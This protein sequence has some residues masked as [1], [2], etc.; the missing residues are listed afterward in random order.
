MVSSRNESSFSIPAFGT[1]DEIPSDALMTFAIDHTTGNLA[2]VQEFPSGGI[3]PRHFSINKAGT[4]VAV[5]NQLD[6]RVVIIDRDVSSGKLGSIIA[7][8]DIQGEPSCI[9]FNE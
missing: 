8:L 9:I 7:D 2:L 3:Y 4:L 5:G 1:G 6:G